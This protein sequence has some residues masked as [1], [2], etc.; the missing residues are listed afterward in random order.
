MYQTVLKKY[1]IIP[2]STEKKVPKSTEK[3]T[4]KYDKVPKNTKTN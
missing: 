4:T 3:S 2:K 1:Q